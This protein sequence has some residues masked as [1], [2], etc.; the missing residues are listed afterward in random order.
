M[1]ISETRLRLD[2]L[3]QVNGTLHI[4]NK[5]DCAR[6]SPTTSPINVS[7]P[8]LEKVSELKLDGRISK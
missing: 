5:E 3:R 4:C 1:L 2:A 7:L 6:G 8:S